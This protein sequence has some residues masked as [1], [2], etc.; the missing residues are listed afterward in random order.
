MLGHTMCETM[1]GVIRDD[2]AAAAEAYIQAKGNLNATRAQ[3]AEKIVEAA[4][5]KMP[6]TE[7]IE[8]SGYTREH[9]RRICR[10]AGIEPE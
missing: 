4:R 6:Q 1:S 9:V 5:T 7:I 8:L 2:L 10:Q 3:L